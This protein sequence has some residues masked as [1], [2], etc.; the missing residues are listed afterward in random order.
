MLSFHRN[1]LLV[2]IFFKNALTLLVR[3]A[4]CNVPALFSEGFFSMK[5][6]VWWSE[7]YRIRKIAPG[8]QATF[9]CPSLSGLTFN[10]II[11]ETISTHFLVFEAFECK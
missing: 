11:N 8:T 5:K 2:K 9:K 3:G 4:Q 7:I 6:G 10:P 1:S